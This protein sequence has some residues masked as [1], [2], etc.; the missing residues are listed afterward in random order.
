MINLYPPEWD[1]T[2]E[3]QVPFEKYVIWYATLH[4]PIGSKRV[5]AEGTADTWGQFF[6]IVEDL[7]G[8][9]RIGLT[10]NDN[11][12]SIYFDLLGRRADH[13]VAGQMYIVNG[14]KVVK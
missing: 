6:N 11:S 12:A 2:P 4:V 14:K 1:R 3:V 13:P 7:T 5:Y 8:I 9:K 10:E